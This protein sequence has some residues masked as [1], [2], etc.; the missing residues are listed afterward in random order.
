M[1]D[2]FLLYHDLP[3]PLSSSKHLFF[4]HSFV[5]SGVHLSCESLTHSDVRNCNF[6]IVNGEM[7]NIYEGLWRSMTNLGISNI[8]KEFDPVAR[9]E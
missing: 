3:P 6:R 7:G 8:S 2:R 5:S 9:L 1:G 4:K